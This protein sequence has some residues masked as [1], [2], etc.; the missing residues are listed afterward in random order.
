MKKLA[1]TFGKSKDDKLSLPTH[2]RPDS[3]RL[4]RT[5]GT[6]SIVRKEPSSTKSFLELVCIT[7]FLLH[8]VS[9]VLNLSTGFFS[10]GIGMSI[11]IAKLG[12][13]SII[14]NVVH[15]WIILDIIYG[16][17]FRDYY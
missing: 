1:R 4:P 9:Y 6:S 17:C 14:T 16:I 3:H 10:L 5:R 8:C 13:I 7:Y 12:S 2:G 11:S 15:V